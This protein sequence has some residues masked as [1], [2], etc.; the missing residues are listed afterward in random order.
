[1]P[2]LEVSPDPRGDGHRF[3]WVSLS[4]RTCLGYIHVLLLHVCSDPDTQRIDWQGGLSRLG[5]SSHP[6]RAQKEKKQKQLQSSSQISFLANNSTR[7]KK[8][9][10][11]VN[12]SF[13]SSKMHLFI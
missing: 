12:V 8:A 1:M 2:I 7:V 6:K 11:R 10:D 13:A 5:L 4:T 3:Q 9:T